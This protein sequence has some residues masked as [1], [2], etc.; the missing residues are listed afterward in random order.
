[1]LPTIGL[2]T[3]T[4]AAMCNGESEPD[5]SGTVEPRSGGVLCLNDRIVHSAFGHAYKPTTVKG[6]NANYKLYVWQYPTYYVITYIGYYQV[7]IWPRSSTQ[8]I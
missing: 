3:L 6:Y 5:S 1:M 2:G 4:G 8:A 7:P